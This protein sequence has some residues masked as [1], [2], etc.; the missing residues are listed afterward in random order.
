[1]PLE[2]AASHQ[3]PNR[4]FVYGTL[5]RGLSN[6]SYLAGQHFVSDARTQPVYRLYDLGG[7]PGMVPSPKDGL[8]IEGEIWEIDGACLHRLDKLEDTDG[9]EYERTRVALADPHADERIEGYLYLRPVT[10]RPDM[11]TR[12]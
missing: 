7:Y 9:G 11:G 10:G 4:I 1:M 2:R 5:K 6:H 3:P 8:S 12:W